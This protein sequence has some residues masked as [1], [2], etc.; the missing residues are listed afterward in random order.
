LTSDTRIVC[1]GQ[2]IISVAEN[3]RFAGD[4]ATVRC[5]GRFLAN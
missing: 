2:K 1:N 3:A 4:I 5:F